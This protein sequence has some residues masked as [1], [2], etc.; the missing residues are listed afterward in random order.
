M[1]QR[2]PGEK[3]PVFFIFGKKFYKKILKK[4]LTM[5]AN[6]YIII[7]EKTRTDKIGGF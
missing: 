1:W 7:S 3:S 4:L 2:Y 6:A 5:Y